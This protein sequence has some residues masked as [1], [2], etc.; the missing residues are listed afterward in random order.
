MNSLWWLLSPLPAWILAEAAARIWLGRKGRYYAWQPGT[1]LEMELLP[2]AFP[3]MDHRVRFEVNAAGER[4]DPAPTQPNTFR[5]LTAGDST[6]E[7]YMIDQEQQISHRIQQA[8][9]RP[10]SLTTLGAP[11]VHVGNLGRSLIRTGSMSAMLRR[12]LDNYDRV[13]LMLLFVGPS[14]LVGWVQD[15]CPALATPA[16]EAPNEIFHSHPAGPFS[17]LPHRSAVRRIAAGCY[18]RCMHRAKPLRNVGS[19][20]Q[21]FR[22]MRQRGEFLETLPDPAGAL[23]SYRGNLRALIH[24]CQDKARRVVLVVP[25][26]MDKELSPEEDRMAWNCGLG[27]PGRG[28]VKQYLQWRHVCELLHR[29]RQITEEVARLCKVDVIEPTGA[30]PKDSEHFY[31]EFHLTGRGC[32]LVAEE[33]AR[34]LLA[35]LGGA[36]RK[37]QSRSAGQPA[38]PDVSQPA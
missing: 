10:E 12:V 38:G 9:A 13:D 2:E 20:L 18:H 5:V 8:L 35:A 14:D 16:T 32:S 26:W 21:R 22:A 29:F 24:L 28:E 27:H 19:T 4:S 6:I 3:H 25:P 17:W 33:I 11:A 34:E 7:C 31:D 36:N 23:Q 37:G 15:G 1:L 30:V